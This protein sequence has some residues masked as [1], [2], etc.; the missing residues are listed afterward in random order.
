MRINPSIQLHHIINPRI[1]PYLWDLVGYNGGLMCIYY[2]NTTIV[3]VY[4]SFFM[5]YGMMNIIFDYFTVSYDYTNNLMPSYNKLGIYNLYITN[6]KYILQDVDDIVDKNKRHILDNSKLRIELNMYVG[7][8]RYIKYILFVIY[9]L[10]IT[11][12]NYTT[13][14]YNS[15]K[16][17]FVDLV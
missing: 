4:Y 2:Y 16:D 8:N 17:T 11:K 7:R 14:D 9:L 10:G 5:L 6:K 15:F 3:I 12:K 1:C 13:L